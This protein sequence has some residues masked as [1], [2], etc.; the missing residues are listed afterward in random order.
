MSEETQNQEPDTEHL[1]IDPDDEAEYDT[2]EDGEYDPVTEFDESEDTSEEIAQTGEPPESQPASQEQGKEVGET[3][4]PETHICAYRGLENDLFI[5]GEED[6]GY[7]GR[8]EY[9]RVPDDERISEPVM[10]YYE[11]VRIIG[12]RAQQFNYGAKPLVDG[13]EHLTAPQQAYLE[14][15]NHMTPFIIRR[16]L[17]GKRYEEWHVRELKLV[18]KINDPF[19]MPQI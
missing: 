6:G 2:H 19:F 5:L 7:Y 11:M 1:D 13:V 8:M 4:R 3:V 18:H 9:T 14:L 10:T 12:T 17:P 16:Y 15:I